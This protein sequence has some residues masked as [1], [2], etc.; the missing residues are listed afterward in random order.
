MTGLMRFLRTSDNKKQVR[1]ATARNCQIN[2]LAG[3]SFFLRDSSCFVL[4]GG[5]GKFSGISFPNSAIVLRIFLPIS[6]CVLLASVL[7]SILSRLS[8]SEEIFGK[9]FAYHVVKNI[10]ARRRQFPHAFIISSYPAFFKTGLILM[11]IA[12]ATIINSKA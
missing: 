10:L 8:R 7:F 5:V 1:P 2:Y 11:A 12:T 3:R 6:K 4:S 9:L